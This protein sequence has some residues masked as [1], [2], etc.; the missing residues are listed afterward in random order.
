M[1]KNF[2]FRKTILQATIALLAII[3]LFYRPADAP[4]K[5]K[6]SISI[7]EQWSP[8]KDQPAIIIDGFVAKPGTRP[9]NDKEFFVPVS[10]GGYQW[11]QAFLFVLL[12]ASCIAGVWLFIRL[13]YKVLYNIA[14]GKPF[15]E[16]NTKDLRRIGWGIIIIGLVMVTTPLLV[17]L[18]LSSS[19]RANVYYPF[20][21]SFY[22][23]RWWLFAGLAVLLMTRAFKQ[24]YDLQ[25]ENTKFI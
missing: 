19:V 18:L 25:K 17:R 11:L 6:I 16:G 2:S 4:K 20:W 14:K 23:S 22:D 10:R 13:P 9:A 21:N 3:L 7:G 15:A 1:R 24:G 12:I 8:E 5:N